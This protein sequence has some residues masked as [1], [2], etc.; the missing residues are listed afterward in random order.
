MNCE[1]A[2]EIHAY[3]DGEL[4]SSR[5]GAVEAHL[6][7]CAECAA[8]LGELRGLSAMWGVAPRPAMPERA[9]LRVYGGWF[10]ARDRGMVRVASWMTAAAAVLLVGALL[11]RPG[12]PAGGAGAPAKTGPWETYAVVPPAEIH[13]EPG[14]E[15]AVA[16]QWMA[17]DLSVGGRR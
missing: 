6:G 8:L 13:G 2:G 3:H 11:V 15:L 17:D 9:V 10:E 4:D 1:M 7:A 16:A 12:A 5:R 14:S